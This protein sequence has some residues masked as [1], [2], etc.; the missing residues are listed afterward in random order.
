MIISLIYFLPPSTT[1]L[2]AIE[3]YVFAKRIVDIFQYLLL[4]SFSIRNLGFKNSD[5]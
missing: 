4:P 3:K 1:K 2:T 5:M